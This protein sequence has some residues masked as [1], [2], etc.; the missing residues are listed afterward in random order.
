M[1]DEQLAASM[2]RY[3]ATAVELLRQLRRLEPVTND[4]K[5]A[6]AIHQMLDHT[7]LPVILK[8]LELALPTSAELQAVA[9]HVAELLSRGSRGESGRGCRRSPGRPENARPDRVPGP[10]ARVS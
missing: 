1:T 7:T 5:L 10:S 4:P 6:E 3:Q 2:A 9:A 8:R